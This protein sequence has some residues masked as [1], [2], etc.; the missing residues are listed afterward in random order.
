MKNR[1]M[2]FVNIESSSLILQ[3]AKFKLPLFSA[4]IQWRIQ[5]IIL[6]KKSI[7]LWQRLSLLLYISHNLLIHSVSLSR[8]SPMSSIVITNPSIQSFILLEPYRL[9]FMCFLC[10]INQQTSE[11]TTNSKKDGFQSYSPNLYFEDKSFADLAV[12]NIQL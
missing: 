9:K 10:A 6:N 7:F 3:H 1:F 12:M 4:E 2:Q 11:D 5:N 8:V